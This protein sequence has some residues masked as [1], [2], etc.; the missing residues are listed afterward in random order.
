MK[1]VFLT[2]TMLAATVMAAGMTAAAQG[3]AFGPHRPP[4]ERSFGDFGSH[5]RFWNDPALVGKLNL[6]DEQ[7]KGMDQVLQQHLTN[8]VDLHANLE[9]AELTLEP[10]MHADQ[11]DEPRILSQIDAVAQA[12]A[13]LEKANARYLIAIRGKFTPEQWKALQ[14]ARA[15]QHDKWRNRGPQGGPD[16]RPHPMHRSGPPQQGAPDAQPQ[17]QPPSQEE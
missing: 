15:E 12:R 7:R 10:L 13:E 4:V 8:L 2:F 16:G 6:T 1:H 3:P 17:P 11:P 5:G 14:A 9:K